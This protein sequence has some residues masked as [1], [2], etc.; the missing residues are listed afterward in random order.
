MPVEEPSEPGAAESLHRVRVGIAGGKEPQRGVVTQVG[1]E[2]GVPAGSED[3]Q[4]RVETSQAGGAALDQRGVQLGGPAKRVAG[5]QAALGVKPLGVQHRQPGQQDRVQPVALGVLGVVGAQVRGAFR[6]DQDHVGALPAEPR[7]QRHPGVTGRFHHDGDLARR[8]SLGEEGP[9]T[10]QVPD[11]GSE[12]MPGPQQLATVIS[13]AGLVR[14]TDRDVDPHP[15]N[16]LPVPSCSL[17]LVA[18]SLHRQPFRR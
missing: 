17:G 2:R 9:Q 3:L 10:L 18:W 16:H 5:T 12:S 7:R 15:K 6:G 4:Q 8:A 1:T 14:R 13:Q 11:C